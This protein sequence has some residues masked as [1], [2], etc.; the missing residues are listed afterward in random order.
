MSLGLS[1]PGASE[2]S[3]EPVSHGF[4]LLVGSIS[5]WEDMAGGATRAGGGC[6]LVSVSGQ[7]EAMGVASSHH[8]F[9]GKPASDFYV[10]AAMHGAPEVP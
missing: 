6:G 1:S 9:W 7:R 5:L 8:I 3:L 10:N 2:T 4:V